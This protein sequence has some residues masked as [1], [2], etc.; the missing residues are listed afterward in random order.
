MECFPGVGGEIVVILAICSSIINFIISETTQPFYEATGP[1]WL[2][3]FYGICVIISLAAG[4][5]VY[6]WG[7][8]WR[9]KCAPR[10]YKFLQERGGNTI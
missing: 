3:L 6:V 9:R 10:Y 7:K 2:F 5:A 4:M 1:G 8:K